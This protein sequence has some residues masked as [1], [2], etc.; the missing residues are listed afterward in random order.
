MF[1]IIHAAD[2]LDNGLHN[3]QSHNSSNITNK[4]VPYQEN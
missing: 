4:Y 1:P 3:L 2:C